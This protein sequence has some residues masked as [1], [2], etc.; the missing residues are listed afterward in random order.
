MRV[1][2]NPR[3]NQFERRV[4]TVHRSRRARIRQGALS[5]HEMNEEGD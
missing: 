5:P 4:W 3:F 1:C 2:P